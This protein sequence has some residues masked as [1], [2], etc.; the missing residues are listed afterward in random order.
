MRIFVFLIILFVFALTGLLIPLRPSESVLEN[1]TLEKFPPFTVESFLDGSYFS[2]IS[3]WYADTF[4][5]REALLSANASLEGLY[6]FQGEQYVASTGQSGDE[7]PDSFDAGIQE[8]NPAEIADTEEGNTAEKVGA[9]RSNTEGTAEADGNN[10]EETA[11]ADGS[12]MEES[13]EAEEYEDGTIYDEPEV[14][15]DVYISGDTAFSV[16]YFNTEGAND[17]VAMIDKAQKKLDGL[18]DVYTILVPTSVG[19]TLS[20]DMQE[21]LNS[22]DQSAAINYVYEG[23]QTTNSKV[24]TVEIF[25][26][27]KKHNAE[28][29]YFR[30]DH[31]WTALGAYYAYEEFCSVKGITA[32]PIEEYETVEFPDFLGTFYAGSGQAA[33]LK[34][35][36]DMILAYIPTS[37]NEMVFY[38]NEG[39]KYD[40][41]IIYDVDGWDNSTKYSTF[42]AGDNPYEVID[43]PERND[44]SSC[45]V[46]KESF[47]NAFVPFLVDH[48]DKVYVVDYRYFYKYSGYNNSVYELVSEKKISDVILMNNVEA[49]DSVSKVSMLS[50]MFD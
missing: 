36:P 45:L 4:P 16:Y 33:S 43:N 39:E 28:Y 8:K 35:N 6:G 17:Y 22:A 11:G 48:Y 40:W 23:I 34:N 14:T 19:V 2:Q 37:T 30:T 21:K 27:L 12:N 41:N 47:G 26:T 29:I 15:G 7:I 31:H 3:T 42:A 38:D 46:I 18:A 13:A 50:E 10:T 1:R 49:M 32:T 44:G 20:E 24:K 5:F 25:D 9:D